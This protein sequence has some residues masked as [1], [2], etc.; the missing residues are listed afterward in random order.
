M[1]AESSVPGRL[2]E[3][4]ASRPPAQSAS[5]A[6]DGDDA[7]LNRRRSA[8]RTKHRMITT[9]QAIIDEHGTGER[10]PVQAI[11]LGVGEGPF[12]RESHRLNSSSSESSSAPCQMP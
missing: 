5:T 7:I 4:S 10:S 3:A 1:A 9:V 11:V 2:G 6:A 8:G 12:V